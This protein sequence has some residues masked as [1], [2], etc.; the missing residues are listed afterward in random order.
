MKEI[1]KMIKK[2]EKEFIITNNGDKFEG[3][4][5][6]N[7]LKEGKGFLIKI[8]L[9]LSEGFWKNDKKI[10]EEYQIRNYS[11][12]MNK[13]CKLIEIIRNKILIYR[14]KNNIN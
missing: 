8:M 5:W 4:Y 14:A 11:I 10:G 12:K 6:N 13:N 3:Y 1:G 7:N 2:K 9:N